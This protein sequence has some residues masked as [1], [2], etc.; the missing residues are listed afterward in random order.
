MST[1][2]IAPIP[3]SG[4]VAW[5]VAADGEPFGLPVACLVPNGRDAAA[6]DE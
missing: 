3:T 6:G 4:Y 5:F 2:T 1:D